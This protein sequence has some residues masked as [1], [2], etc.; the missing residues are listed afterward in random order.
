M[1]VIAY[2]NGVIACDTLACVGD[3]A[4]GAVTKIAR[5]SSG[6]LAAGAGLAGSVLTHD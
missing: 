3:S 4:L 5:N 1:T 6:D 2:R